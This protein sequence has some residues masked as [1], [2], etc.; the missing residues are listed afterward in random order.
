MILTRKYQYEQKL[1]EWGYNKNLEEEEWRYVAYRIRMRKPKRTDVV[2]GGVVLDPAKV[3]KAIQR[4]THQTMVERINRGR[5]IPSL[6]SFIDT[7]DS[8]QLLTAQTIRIT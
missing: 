1:K 4:Y 5:P 8:I 7:S 2:L 3:Q 6:L